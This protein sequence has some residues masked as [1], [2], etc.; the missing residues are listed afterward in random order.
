MSEE[1]QKNT[2]LT[3]SAAACSSSTGNMTSKY[4]TLQ[5]TNYNWLI[6]HSN[7]Y[8]FIPINDLFAGIHPNINLI[9]RVYFETLKALQ[10]L[11]VMLHV[12]IIANE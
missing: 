10:P 6:I 7:S 5:C 11:H 2:F 4:K 9:G 3:P 8:Y 12:P 1:T